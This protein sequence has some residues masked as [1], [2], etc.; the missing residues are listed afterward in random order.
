MNTTETTPPGSLH[1]VVRPI[2]VFHNLNVA[3]FDAAGQQIPELQKSL[4]TLLAE[5][6]ENSGYNPEGVVVETQWGESWRL[7]R[8]QFDTWNHELVIRWL[9]D[10]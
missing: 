1:P 10:G 3:A 9:G 6:I 7:F 8:T 5:H 2:M 4:A